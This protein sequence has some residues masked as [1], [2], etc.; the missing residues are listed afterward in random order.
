MIAPLDR[1]CLGE[2][3]NCHVHL[4]LGLQGSAGAAAVVQGALR[5]C[6]ADE[7]CG[8]FG[9]AVEERMVGEEEL[10]RDTYSL[11]H[12]S[13]LVLTSAAFRG[14]C[15]P[16]T[17]Y[18]CCSTIAAT[19]S[20][21]LACPNAKAVRKAAVPCGEAHAGPG[22]EVGGC[23]SPIPITPPS[24][25]MASIKFRNDKCPLMPA[26]MPIGVLSL[27]F[28]SILSAGGNP[29]ELQ[30][31]LSTSSKPQPGDFSSSA[32]YYPCP[33][34]G[35]VSEVSDSDDHEHEL[36]NKAFSFSRKGS[37]QGRAAG[38]A[39]CYPGCGSSR[40]AC[41]YCRVAAGEEAGV[42]RQTKHP[43]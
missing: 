14:Q 37:W 26:K 9:V 3:R 41:S 20:T 4:L 11:M 33:C 19:K 7:Q 36:N 8:G 6:A 2:G 34:L 39:H 13:Q 5:Q 32:P 43:D 28:Q 1:A 24:A 16:A 29:H 22:V 27:L 25:F 10:A 18:C 23:D 40:G 31:N 21:S 17:A 42:E 38:S 35:M 15:S 30:F 12:E